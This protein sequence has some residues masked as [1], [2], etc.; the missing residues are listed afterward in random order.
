[1]EQLTGT[2]SESDS[3]ELAHLLATNA[4]AREIWAS[5]EE[6]AA[7]LDATTFAQ[8][9]DP[10][11]ELARLHA[12]QE[13]A[14]PVA[15]VSLLHRY[16]WLIRVAAAVLL[17]LAATGLYHLLKPVRVMVPLAAEHPYTPAK[18]QAVQLLIAGQTALA[19]TGDSAIQQLQSGGV[20]LQNS[21]NGLAYT[22]NGNDAMNT[23]LV[24]AA[25]DYRLTLSDGTEVWLN[26][27]TR[28]RFP[29]TFSGGQ[30]EVYVEGEAYFKVAKNSD[31][32]F[33]VHTPHT[34]VQVLGTAFNINTYSTHET[35]S[36]VE[37]AVIVTGA[38]HKKVPL[39]PGTE[40]VSNGDAPLTIQGFDEGEVLSWM[41]GISYFHHTT[42]QDM[43]PLLQRWF[44]IKV[45][46]DQPEVANTSVTGM[47][48]KNKLPEFLQ[49]LQTSTHLH[50]YFSGNQLHFSRP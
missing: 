11:A 32:P 18:P 15:R 1:M 31:Q 34:T 22:G 17:L 20:Q 4:A 27:A 14:V 9:L 5:L 38:D 16:R 23:L 36:L 35:T 10:A 26:A 30:R 42:L 13:T 12:I 3:E 45:V 2:L 33:V 41:K 24:P 25:A 6:A 37:G 21:K 47:V 50:Y 48:E 8:E 40:A 46:F 19:L 7:V 28:L 44:D 49:D 43:Q 39:R 29:F